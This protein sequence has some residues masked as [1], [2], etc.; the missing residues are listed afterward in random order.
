VE[1]TIELVLVSC[2]RW[3]IRRSWDIVEMQEGLGHPN[4]P[5]GLAFRCVGVL[6]RGRYAV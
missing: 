3:C 6:W 1:R 2:F 5:H 4:Y